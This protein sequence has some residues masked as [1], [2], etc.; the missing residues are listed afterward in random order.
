M[1]EK[2]IAEKIADFGL[3]LKFKDLSG[4][5]AHEAKRR[6]IDSLACVLGAYGSPP[7]RAARAVAPVVKEGLTASVIGSLA[8]TPEHAAFANGV[9][10]RYLDYNDTYLSKEPAHPSDNIAP[11]LACAQAARR[12]GEEL[13]TAIVAA[14][15]VQ[16]R[17]CDAASLRKR[18]WDHVAYGAFSSTLASSMLLGLTGK[19]TIDALG[20]A[21]TTSAALRQT[22][23][24]ELSMWKG[25]AFANAA[26]NAVFASI[27][28][29][30]GITGPSPVFEGEFGFQRLVS[31]P[32]DLDLDRRELSFKIFDTYIKYYPAEYHAQ[33]AIGAAVELSKEIEDV[34]RID[35]VVVHTF[36]A[37]YEIIGSGA[38]KWA[39][40]TRETADHSLP[41]CVAAALMDGNVTLETFSEERLDDKRLLGL[42]SRVKVVRDAGLD[43][44][45]PQAV[46]N[47]VEV[48]LTT[49]E[50]LVRE[51]IYPR[52][53]PKNPLTD[54]EVEE[55]F[56]RLGAWYF[57][58]SEL[59]SVLRA[60]WSLE[61]MSDSGE[62]LR[63]FRRGG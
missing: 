34:S 20:I 35:A 51:M 17:L 2:T 11:A 3:G 45:Y 19:E 43:A 59:S 42:V 22:R 9:M 54:P 46:P 31:G 14:Y 15:E 1:S 50:T 49:G 60:L 36:G 24:G 18:G 16:C 28:A 57:S 40:K 55:K 27:L 21:G 37:S 56:R 8:T 39:P 13:L 44:M 58:D 47:R 26:R 5:A 48:R 32:F 63:L 38:E 12:G 7:A 52:G 6:V 10:I 62:I 41:Y 53:H 23:A 61:D 29:R 25:C 33:S 30:S 4:D